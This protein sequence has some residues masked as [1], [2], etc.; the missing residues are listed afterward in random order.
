M[1]IE[2]FVNSEKK[3]NVIFDGKSTISD[4]SYEDE[5][6]ILSNDYNVALDN[7]IQV[8]K[9]IKF[10]FYFDDIISNQLKTPVNALVSFLNSRGGV[11]FNV[12]MV[13]TKR[14]VTLASG[15]VQDVPADLVYI[16]TSDTETK[17]VDPIDTF[18]KKFWAFVQVH[19]RIEIVSVNAMTDVEAKLKIR[20]LYDDYVDVAYDMFSDEQV[21]PLN[22]RCEIFE[23]F[24]KYET[25]L[26]VCN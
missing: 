18:P 6:V 17:Y 11:Y 23:H 25:E 21:K 8:Y 19:D 7:D 16:R 20:D 12:V 10:N 22:T 15:L 26:K 13:A 9:E 4:A 3:V 2:F 24:V 5:K 14:R 1:I